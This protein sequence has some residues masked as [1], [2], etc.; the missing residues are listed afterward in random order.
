MKCVCTGAC[1]NMR[2]H[3]LSSMIKYG[4]TIKDICYNTLGV[5]ADRINETVILSPGWL[6][7][8]L[9]EKSGIEEVVQSS[10]LFQYKIW[11][12]KQ[13][14]FISTYIKTGFGAPVVMDCILLLALT[15]KCKR[16]I[17]VSS[18]G[19]LSEEINIGDIVIPEY[20]ASGDGAS[21]YLSDDFQ[22]D[23]LGEKQYPQLELFHKFVESTEE[24]CEKH[25]VHWHLGKIFCIDTIMA[26]HNHLDR[27]MDM[28]YN[29]IDMESA[30]AFKT[31]NMLNIPVVAILNVSDNSRKDNKSLMSQRS[32]DESK[33]RRFVARE[34]IPQIIMKSIGAHT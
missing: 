30:V 14:N 8:R 1:E 19:G 34:I 6:P 21:R 17:F 9:F 12:I 13:G 4:T 24:L 23:S 7:D 16:I 28:G 33:Y 15:E 31:A 25:N 2:S 32:E 20:S 10:P 18:V 11:N 29:S 3:L 26:Q 5:D 22:N 27:I